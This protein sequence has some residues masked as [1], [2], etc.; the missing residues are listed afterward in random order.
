L[1]ISLSAHRPIPSQII[2]NNFLPI[3]VGWLLIISGGWS[4][5]YFHKHFDSG[6]DL[7][8]KKMRLFWYA[9]I[10]FSGFLLMN[11]KFFLMGAILVFIAIGALRRNISDFIHRQRPDGKAGVAGS[12]IFKDDKEEGTR[13]SKW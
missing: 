6:I 2:S 10:A 5:V 13:N 11:L 3:F 7:I 1:M 12:R 4:G 8:R 9:L